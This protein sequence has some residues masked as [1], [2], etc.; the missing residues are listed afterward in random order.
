[1]VMRY[2]IKR[3]RTYCARYSRGMY[4]DGWKAVTLHGQRM[5][6]QIASTF[7]FDDDLWWGNTL[8]L[9]ALT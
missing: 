1:M 3:L 8:M 4:A 7:P 2:R 9:N 6:W 5:P